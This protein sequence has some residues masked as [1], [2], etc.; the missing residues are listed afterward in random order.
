MISYIKN[1]WLTIYLYPRL[2]GIEKNIDHAEI[3]MWRR[4]LEDCVVGK[5][6]N[7]KQ[8]IWKYYA[9]SRKFLDYCQKQFPSNCASVFYYQVLH[10][11]LLAI[12]YA[13]ICS[14]AFKLSSLRYKYA[15]YT[16]NTVS[17]II[18]YMN[19]VSSLGEIHCIMTTFYTSYIIYRFWVNDNIIVNVLNFFISFLMF[20]AMVCESTDKHT[21]PIISKILYRD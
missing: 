11:F 17:F 1:N 5:D 21:R 16:G 20:P 8:Y 19:V 9:L 2:F 18:K 14:K 12:L 13:R 10:I 7:Y 4:H 6:F 3:I 15:W